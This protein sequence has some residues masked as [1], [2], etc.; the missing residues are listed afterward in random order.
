MFG[1]FIINPV[2]TVEPEI[3]RSKNPFEN[4]S[5]DSAKMID[6]NSLLENDKLAPK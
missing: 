6:E 2:Q 5:A 3:V 4:I 1:T